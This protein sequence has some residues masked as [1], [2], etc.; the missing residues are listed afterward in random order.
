MAD[1]EQREPPASSPLES[2]ES[3]EI[4]ETMRRL[5][6]LIWSHPVAFQRA[7][8]AL[9]REGRQ[10]ATTPEGASMKAAIERSELVSGSRMIW[11]VLSMSAFSEDEGAVLRSVFIDALATAAASTD[12]EPL[13]SRVFSERI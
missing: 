13:L 5:Q 8:A 1:R 12:L 11:D 4:V 9:V 2:E 7:F 3:A 6:M 10:F